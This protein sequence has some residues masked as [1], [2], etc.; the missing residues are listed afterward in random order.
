M[1]IKAT[2]HAHHR[3]YHLSMHNYGIQHCICAQLAAY[4]N[5]SGSNQ[6]T[7]CQHSILNTYQHA[8]FS[9]KAN[10]YTKNSCKT[11][12]SETT[13]DGCQEHMCHGHQTWPDSSQKHKAQ[14]RHSMNLTPR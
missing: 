7:S 3:K 12:S 1:V 13:S 9:L 4:M 2:E 10:S 6:S 14:K 8:V 11:F 5:M